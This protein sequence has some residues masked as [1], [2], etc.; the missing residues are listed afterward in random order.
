MGGDREMP[1]HYLYGFCE[2]YHTHLEC[3]TWQEFYS[4]QCFVLK[5]SRYYLEMF[6]YDIVFTA[7]CALGVALANIFRKQQLAVYNRFT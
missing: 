6:N 7:V 1:I 2:R 4:L 5:K 3:H